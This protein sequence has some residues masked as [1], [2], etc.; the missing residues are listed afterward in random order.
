MLP[1]E[2]SVAW[3]KR[4]TALARPL[5]EFFAATVGPDYVSHG[6][7]QTRRALGP[8]RWA[9]DLVKVM[10][11]E[12]E[13]ALGTRVDEARARVVTAHRDGV[14]VA[15]G[16]VSPGSGLAGRFAI[17]ED[18]VVSK[19]HR[20]RGVGTAVLEWIERQLRDEGI[21]RIFLE[22]GARNDSAVRFFERHAYRRCSVTLLKELDDTDDPSGEPIHTGPGSGTGSSN[23]SGT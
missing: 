14:L 17:L 9:P 12:L 1:A 20:G 11:G 7:L 23:S 21:C 15:L 22:S 13:A 2:L 5:A 8:G 3:C 4:D 6:E 18:L 16:I 19:S 10:T